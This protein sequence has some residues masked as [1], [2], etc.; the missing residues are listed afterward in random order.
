MVRGQMTLGPRDQLEPCPQDTE[1]HGRA[2]SRKTR[3]DLCFT[4][5]P[6][7]AKW[8]QVIVRDKRPGRP[9]K[10]GVGLRQG[11]EREEGR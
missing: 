4:K 9:G 7:T 6:L 8:R 3:S 10:N 2:S 5:L 11:H 1:K